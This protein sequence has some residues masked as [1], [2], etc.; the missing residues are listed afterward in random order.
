MASKTNVLCL[1]SKAYLY[2]VNGRAAAEP[3][4]QSDFVVDGRSLAECFEFEP[5]R[6]WF[7][8]TCFESLPLLTDGE[9]ERELLELRGLL[10]ASNQL[11]S[12][13]LVLYR[14]HC[15]DDN[16]GV[17]SCRIERS[18]DRVRWSDVRFEQDPFWEAAE[19]DD[20]RQE[21]DEQEE[22]EESGEEAPLRRDLVIP[23]FLFA[24]QAYDRVIETFVK[25]HFE[26]GA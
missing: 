11:G 4:R 24:T 5:Q 12:G 14:C 18:E 15:G 16:C 7:G 25:D 19:D 10:P 20:E 8:Q 23:E 13:R 1:S 3:H 26:R 6:P 22:E 2:E 9:R 17:I 21:Q